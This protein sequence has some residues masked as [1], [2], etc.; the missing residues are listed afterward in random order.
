MSVYHE[1]DACRK[2]K[3][4]TILLRMGENDVNSVKEAMGA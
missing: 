1:G 2:T 3:S 4:G